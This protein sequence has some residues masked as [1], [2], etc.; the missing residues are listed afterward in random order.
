MTQIIS[1]CVL[2]PQ[3]KMSP[4]L[5]SAQRQSDEVKVNR[6][7]TEAVASNVQLSTGGV[8][9]VHATNRRIRIRA[10]DGSLNTKLETIAQNLRQHQGVKE[11]SANQQ[12]GSLVVTFDEN[13][14]T[15]PQMLKILRQ[16]D[17]QQ[18]DSPD[19]LSNIDPFA[20]WKSLDFWK[21]QSISFIPLMTGLAVTGGLG[22]SG[23]AAIPVYMI[24][25]DATRRA[26]DYLG[27][28]FSTS[29]SSKNSD[30]VA[31]TK[32]SQPSLSTSDRQVE[33][34]AQNNKDGDTAVVYRVVHAIAGRIRFHLPQLAQDRA[35]ARRLERLLKTDPQVINVRLNSDA[36][37]IAIVYQPHNV[38]LTHWVSLMELALETNPPTHPIQAINEQLPLEPVN[39]PDE[40][41]ALESVNQPDEAIEPTTFDNTT[42][43]VSRLWADMKSSGLSFSL[44][45]LAKF[46]L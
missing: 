18:S 45:Y 32:L 22:I 8:Q 33:P 17:I 28:Q 1:S 43:D 24:T 11:A 4:D 44:A 30:P 3:S 7:S 14:V 39:Q 37:S 19:S 36:A 41:R 16:F 26:I 35:Y 34:P 27:P 15:L 6:N 20:A 23:L 13:L 9:I 12:T 40:A 29:E 5:I 31:T 42:L 25:S 2:S 21:E 10:T 38:P 46:P